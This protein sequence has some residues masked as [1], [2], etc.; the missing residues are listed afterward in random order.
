MKKASRAE[1]AKRVVAQRSV[2]I[3]FH[4][5][6]VRRRAPLSHRGLRVCYV[7][8]LLLA[9]RL[10]ATRFFLVRIASHS[11]RSSLVWPA[12]RARHRARLRST[13][14]APEFH[15]TSRRIIPVAPAVCASRRASLSP[16]DASVIVCSSVSLRSSRRGLDAAFLW[17]RRPHHLLAPIMGCVYSRT[18]RRRLSQGATEAEETNGT[19]RFSVVNVDDRGNEINPGH[20][21]VTDTDL[22]LRQADKNAIIWPLR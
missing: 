20:I 16:A 6:A 17:H 3:G 21:E 15:S 18:S 1:R 2:A 7:R 4:R 11:V 14:V 19:R 8:L 22:I 5:I 10:L 13:V 12:R 9:S